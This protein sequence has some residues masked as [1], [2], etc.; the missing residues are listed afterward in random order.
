MTVTDRRAWLRAGV[1]AAGIGAGL[2][3]APG[4]AM[5]DDGRGAGTD[6]NHA[7]ARSHEPVRRA[8]TPQAVKRSRPVVANPAAAAKSAAASEPAKIPAAK[9]VSDK[10]AS[11][12]PSANTTAT[13]PVGPIKSAVLAAKAY[14]YGYP[15]M[16]YQRV[17]QTVGEV[18]TLFSLTSFANPDVDPIWQAI[19]GGKR[20]NVDTFYSLAELDLSNGPVVLSIPDMGS[21]YFSFQ[22]T[23]P[24]TNVSGYIGSRTTGYGPGKY[25]IT[26]TGGPEVDI[27]GTQT[28]LVPYSS[29]MAL[30]RTLAG[31][32]ADQQTAIELIKQYS[33]NPSGGAVSPVIPIPK[34]G[35]GYLDAIS[36]GIELNPP[37]AIDGPE[38]AELAQ[39]GV[40]P[41]LRVADANL[42][43]LSTVA[44]ELAVR[45]TAA[46]LPLVVSVNQYAAALGHRGW[47]TPNPEIGDYGTD[48]LFRA[49]VAQAGLLAN[50]PDEA[51]YSA[52]LL[53]KNLMP[54]R[55][56][57]TR[58][59]LLHFEPGEL[60]P[61]DAFWSVTVYD[62]DG[63]LVPNPEHR[64]SVSSSRPEELVYRPDG[65]LDILFALRDPGDPGA[66]WLKVPAGGRFSAYLRMYWPQ[67]PILDGTWQ[68]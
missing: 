28:V 45:S 25:A 22:L 7:P 10:P 57:G 13:R 24:Y 15:L 55:G 61:V 31:D 44:V 56:W 36:A 14:V 30:G 51:V 39:I 3:A 67:E 68:Q 63:Y 46:L 37:P 47:A 49:G 5:A 38:L 64:Y 8:P 1:L 11:D 59:Y 18:N 4:I 43:L 60:P 19:G 62:K 23:D 42:G 9:P 33:L 26:W 17:R 32:E 54:L 27:P 20:P 29:M 53:S 48:Y 41:G 6:R 2:F 65:S 34:P 35:V 50:T 21:R 16:E 52:G 40:G 66:N 12:K 58:P